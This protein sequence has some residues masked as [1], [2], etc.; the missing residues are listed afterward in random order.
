MLSMPQPWNQP[1]AISPGT[2]AS[3]SAGWYLETNIWVLV[4]LIVPRV[5]L[6][7]SPLSGQIEEICICIFKDTHT[8]LHVG[9][10]GEYIHKERVREREKMRD[11]EFILTPPNPIQHFRVPAS[12]SPFLLINSSSNSET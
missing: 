5:P 10:Y 4:V 11:H 2:L 9:V 7:L 12:L 8:L 6:S 3:F 1:L